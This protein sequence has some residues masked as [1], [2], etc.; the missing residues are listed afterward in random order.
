[1]TEI[2]KVEVTLMTLAPLLKV[3]DVIVEKN[4]VVQGITVNGSW[5]TVDLLYRNTGWRAALKV[6]TTRGYEIERDGT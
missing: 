2:R 6:R 5:V 1:M 3:G 4:A